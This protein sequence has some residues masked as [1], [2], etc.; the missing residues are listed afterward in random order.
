MPRR[1]PDTSKVNKQVGFKPEMNLDGILK[2][3]INFH[4]GQQAREYKA[5]AADD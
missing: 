1:I 2:S 3:V 4:S 5:S